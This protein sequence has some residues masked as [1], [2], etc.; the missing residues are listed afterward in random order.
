[1]PQKMA[2]MN[3]RTTALPPAQTAATS[4]QLPN[5]SAPPKKAVATGSTS[6]TLKHWKIQA[7]RNAQ[8][9]YDNQLAFEP[10]YQAHNRQVFNPHCR[11]IMKYRPGR[12][13]P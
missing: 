3:G 9:P 5:S 10:E 4:P 1:M 13:L 12:L 11:T 7:T 6:T 2:I 8:Y